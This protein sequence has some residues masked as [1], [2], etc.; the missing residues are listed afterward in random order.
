MKSP[1]SIRVLTVNTHK[2]FTALNRR[3]VLHELRDAVRAVDADVVFLQEVQGT[4]QR[5]SDRVA[6]WPQAPHYEFIADELWPQFAYGRNAVYPHGDHGNA[7]LSKYPIVAH[8]NHDVSVDGHEARGMLH[9][10]LRLPA[11]GALVHAVCVHLGL[12]EAHRSRQLEHLCELV[13]R[14]VPDDAPLVVAGDFNDWRDR[15]HPVLERGLGLHEVFVKAHGR[16]AR[17]FPARFPLLRLDRIYVRN[18]RGHRPLPL[19]R[20]PWA[21]LSDHAPLAAEIAL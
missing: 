7:L 4:H 19:P 5:H 1:P 8:T 16:S 15:A 13:R 11:D 3:F 9:C 20:R 18:A 17:T 21:H 2:G 6:R 14:E 12:A 10:T